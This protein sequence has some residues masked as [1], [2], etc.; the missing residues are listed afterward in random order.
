[1]NRFYNLPAESKERI[2]N[3]TGEKSNL[4]A[5]A[6]EKDWWVVQALTILFELEIGKHLVFKGG[7]SLSKSWG[8]IERFSEDIDLAVDRT[9]YGFNGELTKERRTKL[10][11]TANAYIRETLFPELQKAFAAK[12]L[13]GVAIELEKITTSD[14][15]P[16]IIHV[17]YPN[18]IESPGY[19]QPRVQI[20]IGCRSMIE[21][22]ENRPLLSLVD[23]AY[24]ETQ[25]S[26]KPVNIPSVVPERT[27]LEKTFLLHEEFQRPPGKMRVNRLSRH[28]YDI[29]KLSQQGVADK[30]LSGKELY[31][32][33]VRHRY[34]FARVGDVD[35][36]F[37][38][39]KTINF[40]PHKEFIAAWAEDYKIMQ[41][42]MI[43][44]ASPTFDQLI[45]Y[46]KA[47]NV[48]I[49]ELPWE[50]SFSFKQIKNK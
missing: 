37:H 39:P 35:Y 2:L 18:L 19:I 46:L 47:L 50:A 29:Y 3:E 26:Q 21:P 1:M 22:F 30:A 28:L 44:G 6:V 24:P 4:P 36:N 40:I 32:T 33:I 48:K 41:E 38:Q 43:Y 45:G 15:D 42:Q 11:K 14:Q 23:T 31:E 49:N 7:T 34:G 16:V 17:N 13:S 10:R 5:Y 27:F 20:E 9:F 12:G 8:L 25:F